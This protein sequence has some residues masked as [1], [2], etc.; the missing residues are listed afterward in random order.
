[1]KL[2]N[3]QC[4]YRTP[5]I[6]KTTSICFVIPTLQMGGMERVVCLL[7]N[8]ASESRYQVHIVCLLDKNSAYYLKED[9]NVIS[10]NFAYKRGLYNKIRV[11][12]Y[13]ISILRSIK[14]D[15]IL[16]FSEVFNPLA[17]LSAKT[18]NVPIYISDRSSPNKKLSSY[19]QY[20]R[21]L[22]YPLA[23]GVIAQTEFSKE[24]A[25]NKRYNSN[26]EVIANP[27]K[28]INDNLN[29]IKEPIIISVG[30]L[31]S[32]KNFKELIDIF[33]ELNPDKSWQLWILGEGPDRNKLQEQI[34]NLFL[35]N[36]VK[37][38]GAVKDIDKYLLK[39]SIFA[40]TSLSEGFPNA[41]S[42]ALACPLPCIAYDCP[43][44]PADLIKHGEN[45]FL[46]P[47]NDKISFK[48][49]LDMLV[50]DKNLRNRMTSGFMNHRNKYH[51]KTI[52]DEYLRFI[53]KN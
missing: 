48:K 10:P 15:S 46:I 4:E 18:A 30:R 34:D 23:E 31:V 7:A 9:I 3:K 35:G 26:I 16:S 8:Y 22:S 42:E 51:Y 19:K 12:Y 29:L 50:R 6:G 2:K 5:I 40:F 53:T 20:L 21:R 1:M 27:L 32:T 47:L 49:H 44:G 52:A 33:Y 17:I 13:L 11:L 43:A 41:L 37:L 25:L 28:E 14:P 39:A 45:G 36:R 24:I 38:L